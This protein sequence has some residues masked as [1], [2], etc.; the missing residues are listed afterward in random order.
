MPA[1]TE[2]SV[3]TAAPGVD[4]FTLNSK[5]GNYMKVGRKRL[6]TE[7][8]NLKHDRRMKKIATTKMIP[9]SSTGMV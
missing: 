6:K 8:T 1:P 7:G 4:I 9:A 2:V 3:A 5:L